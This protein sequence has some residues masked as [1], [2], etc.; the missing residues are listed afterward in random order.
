MD[1]PEREAIDLISW[2]L[3]NAMPPEEGR[4][5]PLYMMHARQI[6]DFLAE[7]VSIV[8]KVPRARARRVRPRSA[9]AQARA[10]F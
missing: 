8:K 2:A 6:Y 5:K 1:L 4:P 3:F 9:P 10:K 7:H